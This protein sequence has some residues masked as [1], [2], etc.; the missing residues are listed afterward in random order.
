MWEHTSNLSTLKVEVERKQ[1]QP[2]LQSKFKTSLGYKKYCL[3]NDN[4]VSKFGFNF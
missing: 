4:R 2:Q 3:Q 1:G